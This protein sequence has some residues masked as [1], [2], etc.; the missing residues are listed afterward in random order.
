MAHQPVGNSVGLAA[1]GSSATSAAQSQQTNSLRVVAI[2]TSAHVVIGETAATT[3]YYI[4]ADTPQVINLGAVRSQRVVA[5]T[6]AAGSTGG[7]SDAIIDVPEGTGS[8]FAVGDKVTLTCT[9]QSWY[10]FTYKEVESVNTSAGVN[11]YFATRFR[12][13]DAYSVGFA[14]AF[15]DNQQPC[16]VRASFK[17][18]AIKGGGNNGTINFQQVQVSGDA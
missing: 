5:I 8:Q 9:G 18:S 3:D 4:P 17:V 15:T 10:S 6:T 13:A 1:G 11:G 7:L 2:T 16:E 14:T 12:V